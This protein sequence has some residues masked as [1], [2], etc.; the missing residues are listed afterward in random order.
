MKILVLNSGSSSQKTAL[1]EFGPGPSSDPVSPLWEGKVDWDGTKEVLTVKNS[2]GKRIRSEREFG[3][4]GREAS[5]ENLLQS[6][7][8]GPTAVLRTAS[9]VE[10]VGH[11]IVHGGPKLT[12]P[13]IVT[14]EVRQAIS[15][16]SSI[17]PLHNQA[18]L[19]G[20]D[21]AAMLFPGIA[22]VAVFD[23]GFHRTLPLEAKVYA[24]PYAW[25]E[26][27]IRRYGFHGINHEYCANRAA[28]MLDRDVSSLKIITCHLGNGCSLAAIDGG[29]SVDTTMGFT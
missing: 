18:G 17:A 21:L 22:Q 1:F 5:V 24:G 9:E 19:Q 20:I 12:Q 3:T 27:G 26:A 7:W 25:Y 6:L 14:P 10:A 23:T 4:D 28:Q 11:R 13:A 29:K 2:A 8:N 16:V 15:D